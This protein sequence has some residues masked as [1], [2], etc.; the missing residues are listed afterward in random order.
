M[1]RESNPSAPPSPN[2]KLV[3]VY[4]YLGI[5]DAAY[6]QLHDQNTALVAAAELSARKALD[7]EH[8]R[9]AA[10]P[11]RPQ[12][13]DRPR[14]RAAD[15]PRDAR[16]RLVGARP[17]AD[18]DASRAGLDSKNTARPNNDSPVNVWENLYDL[19]PKR[20]ENRTRSELRVRPRRRV[21]RA[22]A[23][24]RRGAR[25]AEQGVGAAPLPHALQQA[26][27][28]LL[29]QEAWVAPAALPPPASTG[30]LTCSPDGL[31]CEGRPS[32]QP[33]PC[34]IPLPEVSLCGALPSR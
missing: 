8:A 21:E 12:R 26:C 23:R 19:A 16:P 3:D 4:P 28:R 13:H 29:S 9:A 32:A 5:R 14:R 25:A 18:P 24:G 30:A 6:L 15:A 1:M 17:R 7:A 11:L 34:P 22:D 33:P 10:P 27:R 20:P 2:R 31:L